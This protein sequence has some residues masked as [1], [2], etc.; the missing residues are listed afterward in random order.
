MAP[1]RNIDRSRPGWRIRFHGR[2]VSG[3][4]RGMTGISGDAGGHAAQDATDRPGQ[5]EQAVAGQPPF[6]A[7]TVDRPA[8][9]QHPKSDNRGDQHDDAA[10]QSG[11]LVVEI[12]ALSL[13]LTF[14]ALGFGLVVI[15]VDVHHAVAYAEVDETEHTRGHAQQHH[16]YRP[17]LLDAQDLLAV[18][19]DGH[20]EKNQPDATHHADGQFLGAAG[21]VI[22]GVEV[23]NERVPAHELRM[24][25][26][27]RNQE[28]QTDDHPDDGAD[29]SEELASGQQ[30][31][32]L[33][34]AVEQHAHGHTGDDGG[35]PRRNL[36]GERVHMGVDPV[37]SSGSATETACCPAARFGERPYAADCFAD[38]LLDVTSDAKPP[39]QIS[40]SASG[41]PAAPRP[42]DGSGVASGT[43]RGART[44]PSTKSSSV[45]PNRSQIISKLNQA[46]CCLHPARGPRLHATSF[47]LHRQNATKVLAT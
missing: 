10:H 32:N 42:S 36:P 34:L 26:A 23:L 39:L 13:A 6:M 3:H 22:I 41:R 37:R 4:G 2:A 31:G 38:V 16:A 27:R 46:V 24:R 18:N 28:C 1:P 20:A 33:T 29:E 43:D 44:S 15:G 40:R 35:D 21:P 19:G 5:P 12:A 14:P 25:H 47:R 8:G 9:E 30:S 11:Q 17:A 45:H 7:A